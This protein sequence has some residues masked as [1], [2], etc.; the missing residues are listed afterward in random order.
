MHHISVLESTQKRSGC[1][2]DVTGLKPVDPP[3]KRARLHCFPDINAVPPQ[4]NG[5]CDFT[6]VPV[7]ERIATLKPVL[8]R[9]P[10]RHV[11]SRR[12][13]RTSV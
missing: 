11:M 5:A 8:P 4:V 12:N 1:V 10:S 7:G 6:I 13:V 9:V 3:P 2:I